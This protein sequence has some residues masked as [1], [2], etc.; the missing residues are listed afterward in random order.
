MPPS[1]KAARADRRGDR[2]R[3]R[4][5]QVGRLAFDQDPLLSRRAESQPAEHKAR[6][7]D[8]DQKDERL[9]FQRSKYEG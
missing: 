1:G 2:I 6:Q 8:R 7:E 9:A 5:V 3:F 4:L